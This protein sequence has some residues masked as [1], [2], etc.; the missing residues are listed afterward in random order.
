MVLH[1]QCCFTFAQHFKV[2]FN[3]GT[4]F[5][6]QC[7]W[8]RESMLQG[9]RALSEFCT[10]R[11]LHFTFKS[12]NTLAF[13]QSK[14]M[15]PQQY[16]VWYQ[17]AH[18]MKYFLHNILFKFRIST[19]MYMLSYCNNQSRTRR[20]TWTIVYIL[21]QSFT[22]PTLVCTNYEAG[23]TCLTFQQSGYTLLSMQDKQVWR[24]LKQ[25]LLKSV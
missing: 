3:L 10:S 12:A 7:W 15:L 9:S 22:C 20:N 17:H 25:A 11:I 21:I 1:R 6:A 2:K 24:G 16:Q 4:Q 19:K 8:P 14:A 5:F 23:K 13:C 18:F